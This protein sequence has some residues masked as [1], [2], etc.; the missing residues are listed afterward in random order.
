MKRKTLST[1]TNST[2]ASL[3]NVYDIEAFCDKANS[4]ET[5]LSALH[6][7]SKPLGTGHQAPSPQLPTTSITIQSQTINRLFEQR[8]SSVPRMTETKLIN[9]AIAH[10]TAAMEAYRTA[11]AFYF[12]LEDG[13]CRFSGLSREHRSQLKKSFQLGFNLS[14]NT[15][16]TQITNLSDYCLVNS[17]GLASSD[18]PLAH[19]QMAMALRLCRAAAE[20]GHFVEIASTVNNSENLPASYIVNAITGL[21]TMLEKSLACCPS[22]DAAALI[23][24]RF[25]EDFYALARIVFSKQVVH[26]ENCRLVETCCKI[27]TLT[28]HHAIAVDFMATFLKEFQTKKSQTTLDQIATLQA[29]MELVGRLSAVEYSTKPLHELGLRKKLAALATLNQHFIQKI[30]TAVQV[31][32]EYFNEQLIPGNAQ[33][34][35]KY[36]DFPDSSVVYA[37]ASASMGIDINTIRSFWERPNKLQIQT[38]CSLPELADINTPYLRLFQIYS[39]LLEKKEGIGKF[40][41][42]RIIEVDSEDYRNAYGLALTLA[43]LA[44]PVITRIEQ[45]LGES[46]DINVAKIKV[47]EEQLDLQAA[48]IDKYLQQLELDITKSKKMTTSLHPQLNKKKANNKT[49]AETLEPTPIAAADC[50][51]IVPVVSPLDFAVHTAGY[52]WS[53]SEFDKAAHYYEQALKLAA[54][55]ATQLKRSEIYFSYAALT[56]SSARDA[57][58][59]LEKMSDRMKLIIEHYPLSDFQDPNCKDLDATMVRKISK[60][61]IYVGKRLE[62]ILPSLAKGYSS[63]EKATQLLRGAFQ[64][65]TEYHQEQGDTPDTTGKIAQDILQEYADSVQK[66]AR[67]MRAFP[68]LIAE[69]SYRHK[70]MLKKLSLYGQL[71]PGV[72]WKKNPKTLL[73]EKILDVSTKQALRLTTTTGFA[74]DYLKL[75]STLRL[76]KSKVSPPAPEQTSTETAVTTLPADEDAFMAVIDTID[77]AATL[78]EALMRFNQVALILAMQLSPADELRSRVQEWLALIGEFAAPSTASSGMALQ[79]ISG[80]YWNNAIRQLLTRARRERENSD[81]QANAKAFE[82]VEKAAG[83]LFVRIMALQRGDAPNDLDTLYRLYSK[84]NQVLYKTHPNYDLYLFGSFA[85]DLVMDS[86]FLQTAGKIRTDADL[87]ISVNTTDAN[88]LTEL[89]TQLEHLFADATHQIKL[90]RQRQGAPHQNFHLAYSLHFE[91]IPFDITIS[92]QEATNLST[93]AIDSY[94]GFYINLRDQF[95]VVCRAEYLSLLLAGERMFNTESFKEPNK[96]AYVLKE[97]AK[98]DGLQIQLTKQTDM[99]LGQF[100]DATENQTCIATAVALFITKYCQT[101]DGDCFKFLVNKE[102]LSTM[103]PFKTL[104]TH[105]PDVSV[106]INETRQIHPALISNRPYD[107]LL[108]IALLLAAYQLIANATQ[109]PI[110]KVMNKLKLLCFPYSI[111]NRLKS[112]LKKTE[113]ITLFKPAT[114]TTAP[115]TSAATLAP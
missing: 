75:L 49:A 8:Q 40:L 92:K 64:H 57:F 25:Y 73:I 104:F 26:T 30:T 113:S 68:R 115:A 41:E 20:L 81:V 96:L 4:L 3:P 22:T 17:I 97:L 107:N 36:A 65:L 85:K 61:D 27:F 99:A 43:Y 69:W 45:Q 14:L 98:M 76:Q 83:L 2:P 21:F 33:R 66:M 77:T 88:S 86:L 51:E 100:F 23:I 63:A 19:Q 46:I 105:Q 28:N 67:I 48:E 59:G 5:C 109:Q 101:I 70:D 71:S 94:K 18:A 110:N 102:L 91:S 72:W 60:A 106:L 1:P 34:K 114:A 74:E 32:I 84:L 79:K 37:N 108:V 87:W 95:K 16:Y 90:L 82:L 12:Q 54:E 9:A 47:I 10:V 29:S 55:Q 11:K 50:V 15:F 35:K 78:D 62:F 38:M 56:I 24:E 103:E 7:Q 112:A 13:T 39:S 31:E 42:V 111:T 93:E 53:R 89:K 44:N 52:L 58:I 6:R 80:Y